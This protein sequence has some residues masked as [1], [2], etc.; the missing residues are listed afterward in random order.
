M[1]DPNVLFNTQTRQPETL[2]FEQIPGA[3]ESGTHAFKSD[4][5]VDV[6]DPKGQSYSLP[7]TQLGDALKQGYKLESPQQ[8]GVRQYVKDNQ[9]LKGDVKIGLQSLGDELAFGVPQIIREHNQDPFEAAKEQALRDDHQGANVAGSVGGFAGSLF[10]GGP[11]F[12]GAAKAGRIAEGLVAK[13]LAA[14][15]IERGAESMAKDIG[16]RMA[17]SAA[18]L[19]VE[20]AVVSA[21]RALTETALGDP[22]AA[23]ESVMMGGLIGSMLGVGAAGFGKALAPLAEKA[24]AKGE[25]DSAAERGFLD[26]FKAERA[27]KVLGY[28]QAERNKVG[29]EAANNIGEY[30]L[31]RRTNDGE[32]IIGSLDSRDKILEKLQKFKGE[33]NSELDDIYKKLDDVPGE[34]VQVD[35]VINNLKEQIG[36]KFQG[37][38]AAPERKILENIMSDLDMVRTSGENKM[39]SIPFQDAREFLNKVGSFAFPKGKILDPSPRQLVSRE[40]YFLI[41]DKI[42]EA[43]GRQAQTL[44]DSKLVDAFETR[45]KDVAYSLKAEQTLSKQIRKE[46]GNKMF[47]LTDTITGIGLG[48]G[49]GAI[50]AALGVAGKKLVEK[51]GNQVLANLDS[52]GPEFVRNYMQTVGK[53]LDKI[54]QALDRMGSGTSSDIKAAGLQRILNMRPDEKPKEIKKLKERATFYA[55]NPSALIEDLSHHTSPIANGGAPQTADQLSQRVPQVLSYIQSIMPK[56]MTAPNPFLPEREF[57]ASDQEMAKFE[58]QLG[59]IYNPFS[60]I[61]D[62]QKGSLTK[63]QMDTLKNVYPVIYKNMQLRVQG[64][65]IDKRPNLNFQSRLKLSL[66]M[67]FNVDSS[68]AP[69]FLSSL[70]DNYKITPETPQDQKFSFS[71]QAATPTQSGELG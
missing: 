37:K 10:V 8:I 7:A 43:A 33:A 61:D 62:L 24:L 31:G 1:A 59:V 46:T 71:E 55:S 32:K 50:P 30:F 2:P 22:Q 6:L 5:Q 9:G 64:H 51:Y 18:K 63:D 16:A 54:P 67:G 70:Q 49:I 60:V 57:K 42:D 3:I 69:Q 45:R 27:S 35:G 12:K 23:A 29:E 44:G 34:K 19:G 25:L 48:S 36:T 53:R 66:L 58:R 21:P 47:G 56:P 14:R 4:A 17:T 11:L 52:S 38:L 68:V 40:A 15:G 20:G 65:M 13:E 41:R 39:L 28:T 26:Q